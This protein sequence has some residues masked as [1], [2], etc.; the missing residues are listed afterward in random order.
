[1]HKNDRFW[2]LIRRNAMK[3][4]T[5]A[6][7][8]TAAIFVT[9]LVTGCV[10]NAP[11]SAG[12][13]VGIQVSPSMTAETT[14]TDQ[15]QGSPQNAGPVPPGSQRQYPGSGQSQRQ[16][17]VPNATVLAGAA[18]KLGIPQG[19]LETALTSPSGGRVNVTAA[20]QELG[21]TPQQLAE[22]LGISGGGQA[23]RNSTR[24]WMSAA[25]Q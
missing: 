10:Q 6:L 13:G 4:T 19:Q 15:Y 20:A 5:T 18:A 21:I 14:A 11:A 8:F 12:N 22:A 2:I 1:M 9:L 24:S 3:S 25:G 23:P 16:R 17:S 7:I